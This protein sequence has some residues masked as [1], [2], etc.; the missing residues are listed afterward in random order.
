M[1][2]SRSQVRLNFSAAK[3]DGN[4]RMSLKGKAG[5]SEEFL[6]KMS[7]SH[8]SASLK[9]RSSEDQTD[10]LGR[11]LGWERLRLSDGDL[12]KASRDSHLDFNRMKVSVDCL[13]FSCSTIDELFR[14]TL[15]GIWRH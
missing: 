10:G 1:S 8:G 14:W 5:F 4:G 2:R 6:D 15:A 13:T 3:K 12:L 9:D 7:D 11:D